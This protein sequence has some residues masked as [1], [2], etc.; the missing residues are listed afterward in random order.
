M[1]II[2]EMPKAKPQ[3]KAIKIITSTSICL[4][5]LGPF[6]IELLDQI[7][8]NELLGF[9]A[10]DEYLEPPEPLGFLAGPEC[11]EPLEPLEFHR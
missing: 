9:L 1:P 2:I 5:L 8:L 6:G 4:G 11:L 7:E 10:L 3:M